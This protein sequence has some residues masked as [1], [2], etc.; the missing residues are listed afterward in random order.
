MNSKNRTHRK[1]SL[2]EDQRE[3]NWK[4]GELL[5]KQERDGAGTGSS[6]PLR[7]QSDWG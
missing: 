4:K 1:T 2:K 3:R 7:L 5:Q 6:F